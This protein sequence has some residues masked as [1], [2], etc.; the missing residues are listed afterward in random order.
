MKERYIIQS[1]L[2]PKYYWNGESNIM[3]NIMKA[4]QYMSEGDC[5]N[6][7]VSKCNSGRYQIIKIY[8]K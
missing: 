3:D 2:F 8:I 6:V 1:V 7:I 5:R 4:S